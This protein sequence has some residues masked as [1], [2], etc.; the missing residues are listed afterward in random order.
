[1]FMIADFSEPDGYFHSD[2]FVSNEAEYQHVLPL[3]VE[4]VKPGGV[5]IGVGP[6]QNFTYITALHPKM[7]FIV[8]IRRQ[9][10]AVDDRV[11]SSDQ[12][13]AWCSA[14]G[15]AARRSACACRRA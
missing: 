1:M 10:M 15:T 5:Y 3:L 2:N 7:A 14:M 6:E 9:N 13:T 8:D 4:R 12:P 11:A